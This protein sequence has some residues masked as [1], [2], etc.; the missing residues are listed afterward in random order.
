MEETKY[1]RPFN[2]FLLMMPAG[3]SQGF[4]FVTLPYMLTHSGFTVAQAASIA[5]VGASASLFRFVLGPIVDVSL[6][7]RK[8]YGLSLLATIIS[9]L[10][11]SVTPLAISG[12]VFLTSLVF[13]SQIAMN[14]MLLPIGAFMAKSIEESKKGKASGW[15]QAGSL[16]GTGLGG[17]AGLWLAEHFNSSIAGIVLTLGCL[18]FALVVLKIKDIDHQKGRTFASELTDLGKDLVSMIRIPVTL[19]V[20][21]LILL[22]IGTG[23]MANLWSAIA[24]DWNTDADTVA[25]VTG[26]LSGL[27]SAFGCVAGGFLAD[28][29]GVWFAYLGSGIACAI[30]TLIAAILPMQPLSYVIGVSLYSFTTGMVYASFTAVLL[31]AIGKKNAATK[32]SLLGS[33]GNVSVVYMTAFNGRMHDQ[34]NS[35]FMLTTEAAFGIVFV[36]IFYFILKRMQNRKLI[37]LRNQ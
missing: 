3:I 4:V 1:T 28:K 33:V 2:I 5:A 10:I 30:V 16:T 19:L 29:K 11:L 35:K 8:W 21:F 37:P 22:P 15:Y 14:V 31:Y 13:I 7:L 9:L 24:A 12:A 17:G 36:V 23:A 6:S 34:Y 25:L 18:A 27:I 20:I 26:I 32:F